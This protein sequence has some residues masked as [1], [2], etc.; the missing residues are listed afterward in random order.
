MNGLTQDLAQIGILGVLFW[1][2]LRLVVQS[3]MKQ[4]R[5]FQTTLENHIEHNTE[6]L[7][8]VQRALEN[9]VYE[10]RKGNVKNV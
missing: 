3:F 6:A 1:Y 7:K 10:T 4:V 2:F 9:L 5:W 8:D